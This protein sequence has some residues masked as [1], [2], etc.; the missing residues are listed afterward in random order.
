VETEIE[1]SIAAVLKNSFAEVIGR[2][3]L[4]LSQQVL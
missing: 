4:I 3:P 2:Y 1:N